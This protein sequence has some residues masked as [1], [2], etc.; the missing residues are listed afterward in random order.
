MRKH[1]IANAGFTLAEFLLATLIATMFVPVT[2]YSLKIAEPMLHFEENIQDEIGISQIRNLGLLSYDMQLV[3][4][5]VMFR[6]QNK[7]VTLSFLNNKIILQP[8]TQIFL[9]DIDEAVF[10]A[11]NEIIYLEYK[12]DTY[13]R[14][15]PLFH[16]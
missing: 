8:G 7:D 16:Q 3:D 12:R 15:T 6:M 10:L 1:S 11:E 13:V 14:K 4:N 2:V 9:S 5:K